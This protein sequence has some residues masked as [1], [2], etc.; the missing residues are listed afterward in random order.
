MSFARVA[1][2]FSALGFF[3]LSTAPAAAQGVPTT[4]AATVFRCP[5]A[6]AVSAGATDLAGT[7]GT[8][9]TSISPLGTATVLNPSEDA[10]NPC[11]FATGEPDLEWSAHHNA[12]RQLTPGTWKDKM[13]VILK[14]FD[15]LHAQYVANPAVKDTGMWPAHLQ[16]TFE[17]AQL[18]AYF[19]GRADALWY[20]QELEIEYK[21]G[22]Y[23]A[24]P[25]LVQYALDARQHLIALSA[26]L[27]PRTLPTRR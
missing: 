13:R 4:S 10:E 18:I 15:D 8:A 14:D 22:I 19:S 6:T 23:D 21:S 5:G 26:P 12:L 7:S 20:A 11:T 25:L 24:H 27:P 2:A 17:L 1:A 16:E 3:L 9:S